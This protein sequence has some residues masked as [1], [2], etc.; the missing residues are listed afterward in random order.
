LELLRNEMSK[1]Y[2]VNILG[3]AEMHWTGAG[4]MNEGEIIWSVE[5]KNTEEEWAF[6]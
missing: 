3:L 5:K 4:E 2:Y 1:Y 6:C